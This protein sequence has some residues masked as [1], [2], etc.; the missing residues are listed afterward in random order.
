MPHKIINNIKPIFTKKRIHLS[1]WRWELLRLL[2]RAWVRRTG[3]LNINQATINTFLIRARKLRNKRRLP[4]LPPRKDPRLRKN[5]CRVGRR[6]INK[7]LYEVISNNPN[8][9][10]TKLLTLSSRNLINSEKP[11]ESSIINSQQMAVSIMNRF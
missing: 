4:R 5:R 11:Q 2:L 9:L 10:Q 1:T 6:L 7:N 8:P 3:A